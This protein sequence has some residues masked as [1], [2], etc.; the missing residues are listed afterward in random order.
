MNRPRT[1]S[2][3]RPAA[4]PDDQVARSAASAPL[5]TAWFPTHQREL[6]WRDAPP[7][8]RDPYRT[9]VSEAMLQQTQVSRV[10]E[11]FTAFIDR[12]PT[13]QSLAA[14]DE[15]DVLAIWAGLGYY[16]RARNLH[17]AAKHVV[18][19]CHGKFPRDVEALLELPG[20]GRYTAGAIASIATGLPAPIVDGN[21]TRVLLRIH[22]HD[23]DQSAPSTVKWAWE[24]A[25][26][27]A[28]GAGKA[29][30]AANEALMELGAT[31]CVP[32]SSPRCEV[33]PLKAI[34]IAHKN[35]VTDRIPRAKQTKAATE[36]TL[37]VLLISDRHDR[38]LCE[39][40]TSD[41]LWAGLWQ[42][43]TLEPATP[44]D[45]ACAREW[46]HTSNAH[47]LSFQ[48]SGSLVRKLTH[49]LMQIE[50]FQCQAGARA[51]KALLAEPLGPPGV[52]ATGIE[53]RWVTRDELRA[54][55]VSNAHAAAMELGL[56]S[57]PAGI[58]R[59]Q[60]RST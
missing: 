35:G 49:R 12:F 1:R 53:R 33:C 54:L 27:F 31:V 37:L 51:A 18:S 9:L 17:N 59:P 10:I 26:A 25:G 11:K 24:Q 22:G 50:V 13:V 58:T 34:C 44:T 15:R 55:G 29:A 8:K 7:G 19:E 46:L 43:P 16:R 56:R 28:S 20:V 14:A 21:V 32:G 48:A 47:G 2:K 6:P 4:P 3:V 23:V 52:L 57:E 39:R 42:P 36:R 30:G 41:G 45:A 60:R 38:V 5:L 40:R